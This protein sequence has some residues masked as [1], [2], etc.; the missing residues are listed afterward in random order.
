VP[1]SKVSGTLK[2]IA[3]NSATIWKPVIPDRIVKMSNFIT[4][5]FPDV[6]A[7]AFKCISL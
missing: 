4:S 6:T 5:E 7:A 1:E 3:I 2:S